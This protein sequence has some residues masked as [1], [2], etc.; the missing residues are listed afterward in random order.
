MMVNEWIV[1]QP[2]S[3]SFSLMIGVIINH[4]WIQL[5]VPYQNFNCFGKRNLLST[6]IKKLD[7]SDF[8]FKMDLIVDTGKY[9][10]LPSGEKYN[11]GTFRFKI[12]NFQNYSWEKMS[13]GQVYHYYQFVDLNKN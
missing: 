6:F 11:L 12:K 2:L 4:K 7:I 3:G 8:N 13:Y 5:W 1:H 10:F 9:E